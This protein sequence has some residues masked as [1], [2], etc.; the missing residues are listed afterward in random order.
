MDVNLVSRLWKKLF[1]NALLCAQLFE[2]MEVAKLVVVHIMGFVGRWKNFLNSNVHEN[3]IT[4]L[5][6]W[7]F[8]FGGVRVCTTILYD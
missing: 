7:A 2:I 1:P 3:Q 4:K 6:L 5:A 8:R